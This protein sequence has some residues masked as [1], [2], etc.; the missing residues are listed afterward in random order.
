MELIHNPVLNKGLSHSICNMQDISKF[1]QMDLER[2]FGKFTD[3]YSNIK[4][5]GTLFTASETLSRVKEELA[6]L[7][8]RIGF[9][10]LPS[11]T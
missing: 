3:N 11:E 10:T 1:E 5:F 7:T 2:R 9:Q 4:Q 6:Q 8:Y